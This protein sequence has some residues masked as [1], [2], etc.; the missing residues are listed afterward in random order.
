MIVSAYVAPW[1][2]GYDVRFAISRLR[3]ELAA[4]ALLGMALDRPITLMHLCHQ[5]V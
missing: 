3:V 1:C 2:C 4:T 5:E